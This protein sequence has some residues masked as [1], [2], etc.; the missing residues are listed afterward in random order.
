MS[1]VQAVT[2]IAILLIL[3]PGLLFHYD[4]T[5]KIAVLLVGTAVSLWGIRRP[6]R[7]DR[8]F[9]LLVLTAVSIAISTAASVNPMFSLFG[10]NWRFFG[11]VP[12][13]VTLMFAWLVAVETAGRPEHLLT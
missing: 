7:Y 6:A 1:L 4:I 10:T 8:F 13:I 5:P 12:E 3:T 2:A 9:L 11:A